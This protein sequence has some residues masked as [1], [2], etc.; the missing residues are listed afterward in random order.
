[1]VISNLPC[2]AQ[3][4]LLGSGYWTILVSILNMMPSYQPI[5]CFTS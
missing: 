4:E 3:L 1:M 2:N 5:T